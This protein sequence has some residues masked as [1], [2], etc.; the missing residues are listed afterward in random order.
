MTSRQL[1]LDGRG[2]R[3]ADLKLYSARRSN[4]GRHIPANSFSTRI[5][6]GPSPYRPGG[7]N[8]VAAATRPVP[9]VVSLRPFDAT[10]LL[11][12]TIGEIGSNSGSSNAHGEFILARW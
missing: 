3:S 4:S 1:S 9:D 11:L 10:A 7:T 5:C 6:T 12:A 2:Y 8:T